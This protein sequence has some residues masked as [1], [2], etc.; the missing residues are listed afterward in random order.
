MPTP[1]QKAVENS[2]L[3]S[4]RARHGVDYEVAAR[5]ALAEAQLAQAIAIK[6][7]GTAIAVSISEL[8]AALRTQR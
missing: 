4:A 2:A 8:A 5:V 6:E 7:V 3:S 1:Y